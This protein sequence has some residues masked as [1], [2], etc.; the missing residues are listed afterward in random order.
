MV[1]GCHH[2]KAMIF[3]CHTYI[4]TYVQFFETY[5]GRATLDLYTNDDV[6]LPGAT[7]VF[8]HET[9]RAMNMCYYMPIH[10][11]LHK[12]SH[13]NPSLMYCVKVKFDTGLHN[14]E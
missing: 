10:S 13:L 12:L 14:Y 11:Y 5:I 8:L 9:V 4:M 6:M 3:K 1:E 7:V 2:R